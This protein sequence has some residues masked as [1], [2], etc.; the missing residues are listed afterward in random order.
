MPN[1]DEAT[2]HVRSRHTPL[3][4]SAQGT[5]FHEQLSLI[6]NTQPFLPCSVTVTNSGKIPLL[7]N[8]GIAL[9]SGI[10]SS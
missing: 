1:Y 5:R 2:H 10:F 7:K 4:N 9:N 3:R 6:D 8:S